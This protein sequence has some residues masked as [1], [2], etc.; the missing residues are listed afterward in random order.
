[1][2]Y[3]KFNIISTRRSFSVFLSLVAIIIINEIY[4]LFLEK[5]ILDRWLETINL[6]VK[7]NRLRVINL[8]LYKSL[9]LV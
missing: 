2:N 9:T 3:S 8:I 5:E 6:K 4:V 1:M 7:A